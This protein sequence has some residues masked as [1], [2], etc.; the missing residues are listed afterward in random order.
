[1]GGGRLGGLVTKTVNVNENCLLAC[2]G[3]MGRGYG[4]FALYTRMKGIFTDCSRTCLLCEN[5]CEPLRPLR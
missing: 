3:R 5:L 4:G 2:V 1:M